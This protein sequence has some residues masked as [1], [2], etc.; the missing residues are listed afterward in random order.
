MLARKHRTV[1]MMIYAFSTRCFAFLARSLSFSSGMSPSTPRKGKREAV[2]GSETDEDDGIQGESIDWQEIDET[3]GPTPQKNGRLVGLFDGLSPE[4]AERVSVTT[5]RATKTVKSPL[6]TP[7]YLRRQTI[8]LDDDEGTSRLLFPALP[9]RGLSTLISELREM[10][11][12]DEDEGMHVLREMEAAFPNVAQPVEEVIQVEK[13]KWKKKGLKRSHRRVIMRPAKHP[14][15]APIDSEP[16]EEDDEY[17]NSEDEAAA[18][19]AALGKSDGT[20]SKNTAPAK[21]PAGI[22]QNYKSLKLRNTG[23]K[24]G[25]GKFGRRR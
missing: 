12:N 11:D 24:G 23:H 17:I 6:S 5:K 8:S 2:N 22:S 13:V 25:R 9:K 18:D 21:R 14:S 7:S 16:P 4:K 1:M 3:I 10:E 15:T 19:I 20:V